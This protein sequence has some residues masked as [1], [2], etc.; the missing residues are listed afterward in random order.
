[1]SENEHSGRNER[2]RGMVNNG[3]VYGFGFIGAAVYFIQHATSFMTGVIGILKAVI[4]PAMLAYKAL[5]LLKM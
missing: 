2:R 1:M 5:E 3:A 4:W